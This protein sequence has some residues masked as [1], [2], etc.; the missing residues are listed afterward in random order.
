MLDV[1]DSDFAEAGMGDQAQVQHLA[2]RAELFVARHVRVDAMQ[3]P[4]RDL[5][6]AQLAQALFD[7]AHQI[8]GPPIGHPAVG[9]WPGRA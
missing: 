2:Y 7:F 6:D 5:L 8:V 1:S 9:T 4:Q 3:L